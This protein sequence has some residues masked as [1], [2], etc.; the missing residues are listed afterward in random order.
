ME[1]D[2]LGAGIST[3][4]HWSDVGPLS[5]RLQ[6]VEQQVQVVQARRW[7]RGFTCPLRQEA[8]GGGRSSNAFLLVTV[9]RCVVNLAT[10]MAV[11]PVVH[12]C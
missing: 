7:P 10:L 4:E 11:I 5:S 3:P 12:G 1:D 2:S 8:L 6:L 9:G